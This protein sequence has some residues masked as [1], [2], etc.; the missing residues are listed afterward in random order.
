MLFDMKTVTVSTG[1]TL[2][3]IASGDPNGVPVIFLHGLSDSHRSYE[4]LL[5]A[6]PKR[7]RAIAVTQRGHGD[8][9]RPAEDY[10]P[11]D[12]AAD[13]EAF[14]DALT[15]P[16]AVIVGHSMGSMVAR[17]FAHTHPERTLGLVLVGA[18]A[19]LHNNP[20]VQEFW[21]AVDCL[22][23]PVPEDF[24]REFQVSTLAVP[25]PDAF[26]EMVIDESLKLPAYVW[27]GAA[28]GLID[29]DRTFTASGS[30]VPALILWG[31]KDTF[32]TR[33]DQDVLAAGLKNA[34]L[35]VYRGTGHAVHWEMPVRVAADLSL[36]LR[37]IENSIGKRAA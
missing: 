4:P 20:V 27:R 3:Y 19:T 11:E 12:M 10:R 28:A 24:V 36:W 8:A 16:R 6:L 13:L 18:F 37:R 1:V 7:F 25:V 26:L 15:I 2:P 21:N 31:D 14:M 32:A 22:G 29:R 23:E 9:S 33:H 5:E 35:T 17:A 34:T 30:M